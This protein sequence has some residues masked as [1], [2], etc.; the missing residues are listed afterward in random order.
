MGSTQSFIISW[1]KNNSE[2]F[3]KS[4]FRLAILPDE[5]KEIKIPVFQR[6][7]IPLGE[8]IK[9]PMLIEEASST[10]LVLKNMTLMVDEFRN[11][12]IEI[13]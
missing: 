11:L 1:S 12:I 3:D 9:G 7:K 4:K 6:D 2:S 8:V 5:K 10:T 13:E